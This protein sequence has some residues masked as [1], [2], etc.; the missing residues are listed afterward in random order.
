MQWAEF[1]QQNNGTKQ[2]P[3]LSIGS[4]C[5]SANFGRSAQSDDYNVAKLC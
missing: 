5:R 3:V 1:F 2:V 4:S